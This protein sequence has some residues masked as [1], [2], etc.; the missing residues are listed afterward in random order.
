MNKN[1]IIGLFYVIFILSVFS[2]CKTPDNKLQYVKPMM[3]TGADGRIVPVAIRPFG[4]VQLA[5]DTRLNASGYHYSDDRIIGFSHIHKS[6]GG[7]TDFLDIMFFPINDEALKNADKFPLNISSKFSHNNETAQPGY[8]KVRLD[9]SGIDVE[10]TATE[11]CGMHRYKYPQSTIQ[12][13]IIDLKHGSNE[14][15]T[16]HPEDNFDTVKVAYLKVINDRT[17]E[18]YRISNG[19]VKT[20]HVYFYAEFSKPFTTTQLY[21]NRNLQKDVVEVKATDIRAIL[22]FDTED[23]DVIARVGISPVSVEGARK[24]LEKEI[25]EWDFDKIKGDTQNIWNESLTAIQIHDEDSPQK[26]VFY[27][28]LYNALF[29]PMLYSDVTG[30]YRGPDVEIHTSDFRYFNGVTGLWD[31]FRAQNPLIA[32]LRPDVTNDF[33]KTFY[34]HYQHYGQLPIWTLAGQ[35]TFC[36]IGYHSMPVIAD[37]YRK[38]I[39]DY[40]VDAIYEAMKYSANIDTFGYFLHDM[41]GTVNYKKYGYVPCD[42]EITSASKTLEYAY[43]DWC[44]AQMAKM[45]GKED[46]YNYYIERAGY[47]KNLFDKD[48]NFMKGRNADGSW[49]SPFNPFLSNHYRPGD[50]F[51]EG[52]SWQWSFFAPHD[53]KGLM[54]LY[55]GRDKFVS[56]LDSLFI[57]SSRIDGDTPAPDIT[58]LIGQY[59]H[60]NEPS[61]STIYMYNYAGQPWKTQ[62]WIN[63]VI[64]N[65]YNTSPE[66]ICGN[67]D[68]GQMSAWY[69]FSAMGFYPVTHGSGIYFIGAPIFKDVSLK[70]IK[71]T[72]RIKAANVSKDNKYIKS[73]TVNGTPYTKSWISNDLLFGGNT[74]LRFEMDN[75]PN[76]E[77]GSHDADLPLSM[78]DEKF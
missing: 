23:D 73:L 12:Q 14:C 70:H 40:D 27:T 39:R 68:T 1:K 4:M 64:Y 42:L 55:G 52:T 50:D 15:C 71:G 47:Y 56:K 49:R 6:G 62:K 7:C 60:G 10:L 25:T 51:C 20:Q 43:D 24:N 36:M 28:C 66:G 11:R 72:L 48:V 35:E 37:A 44:I 54:E 9:D 74:E 21:D 59:A 45:L 65:F 3:G 34:A 78:M 69:V 38:G 32:I 16:I 41:R 18:G 67:D 22:S 57:V 5:P 53:G 46:D 75:T 26:E 77:W 33:I 61:H 31:T 76:K 30:E 58:G 2:F 13:V 29:Y 63:E 17:I 8:Y 19:W